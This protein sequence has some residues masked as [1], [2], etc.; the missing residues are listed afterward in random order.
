[1]KKSLSLIFVTTFAI[2]LASC[3]KETHE[4]TFSTN[5]EKNETAHWH[6]AT[7]EHIDQTSGYG[8]HTYDSNGKCSVCG[9]TKPT[10]VHEHTYDT[11]WSSNSVSHW[12]QATCEHHN[13]MSDLANHIFDSDGKCTVC[14]YTKPTPVHEHTF[15]TKWEANES[16]H[17]HQAT[18]EHTELTSEL[19]NHVVNE[20][21]I[22]DVCG[23]V[24]EEPNKVTDDEWDVFMHGENA[25]GFNNCTID[26]SFLQGENTV[27]TTNIVFDNNLIK[28]FNAT[29]SNQGTEYY[30]IDENGDYYAY[31]LK[32]GEHK[33]TKCKVEYSGSISSIFV[34]LFHRLDFKD[35]VY[36]QNSKTYVSNH[37][38]NV[39]HYTIEN[40]K[41]FFKNKKLVE[42]S[43]IFNG[44]LDVAAKLTYNGEKVILPEYKDEVKNIDIEFWSSFGGAYTNVLNSEIK[45]VE[46]KLSDDTTIISIDHISKGSFDRIK[47]EMM[48]GI[49]TGNYPDIVTGYPEHFVE[50]SACDIL[51]PLDKL[52]EEYDKKHNTQILDDYFPQ[53]LGEN[54]KIE[55]DDNGDPSLMALPFSKATELMGYNGVFV[56]YCA[57]IDSTLEVVPQTWQEWA[58]KGPK[59]REILDN[60]T[61]NPRESKTG[62]CV[63]GDQNY[64]GKASNFS[65]KVKVNKQDKDGNEIDEDGRKL[66]LDFTNV[67]NNMARVISW[68]STDNMFIT[69]IKQWGAEYTQVRE[70]EMRKEALERAGDVLFFSDENKPK[71]VECLKFFNN[72]NK[73][74]VFGVPKEFSQSYSSSAFENNQ[75]MFMLCSS[76]GLSY[77]TTKWTN[78]FRVAPLPYYDDGN[79]V[80]KYVL[81]TGADICLT[82]AHY[83]NLAQSF[84]AMVALTTGE[85]QAKWC[86]STGYYPCSK[87]AANS[88]K[89]QEFLTEATPG[90]KGFN[91]YMQETGC[92]E[93][94]ALEHA[95]EL[96]TKV[97]YREGANVNNNVYMSEA[98]QWIKFVDPAFIGSSQ[99]RV[100]IRSI[101]EI[102]FTELRAD[103]QDS[104]YV[105]ILYH[106]LNDDSIK[107]Y[108]TIRIAGIDY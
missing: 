95:Y 101:F 66:L 99:I 92:T 7:C 61:A 60:L 36:D 57:T 47:A 106:I 94:Q 39:G 83:D 105:D 50:Y 107:R 32:S 104:E 5:W 37:K 62:L 12:H 69:L 54:Y 42:L 65:V 87:S 23:Y 31:I 71:V 18:C 89:Y 8:E 53:Y 74:K 73:Q 59:Y 21:G 26:A 98:E 86:L 91:K 103:A 88:E 20:D 14:G 38:T 52:V 43:A 85:E 2:G 9:Y 49:A 67:D 44:T 34:D 76:G 55:C 6:Q 11:R 63:Y 72:L 64:E 96:P 75:V 33:Y 19:G 30:E 17:W 82:D 81:S 51:T 25:F 1:M 45:S 84:E 29:A 56:D 58:V 46:E 24:L 102:V 79:V 15:D 41:M 70:E 68:D 40:I 27:Q 3:G 28:E 4:H 80:R 97:A 16:S 10:P 77:N 78:R 108:Q 90:G 22:C 13:L 35:F 48:S 93:Q 100:L